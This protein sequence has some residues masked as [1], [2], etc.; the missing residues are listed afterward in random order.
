M[1]SMHTILAA[2]SLLGG[3]VLAPHAHAAD[4]CKLEISGNDAIQFDK[5]SLAVPATCKEITVTLHHIGQ[6]GQGGH[7]P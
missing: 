1:K 2:A 5:Q 6:A 4:A 7:G 3:L